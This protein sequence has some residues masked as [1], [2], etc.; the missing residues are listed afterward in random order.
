MA[1]HAPRIR[2]PIAYPTNHLVSVIDDRE[3][4]DAA[5]R[6]LG[7]QGFPA[8]DVVVIHGSE[9]DGHVELGRLGARH[10]WLTRVIR[11]VQYLTMDQ[12]PDFARY[13]SALAGGRSV[14]AVHAPERAEMLRARDVLLA[15]G[16]HFVN[17]YGRVAT[18]ELARWHDPDAAWIDDPYPTRK[19]GPRAGPGDG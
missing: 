11:A 2:R 3:A 7:S 10:P 13:E 1:A 12:Q 19:R 5:A 9:T 15:A 8:A 14:V 18:E 4:A 6:S 17:Y 16:A